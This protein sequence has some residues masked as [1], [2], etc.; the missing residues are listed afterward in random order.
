MTIE[1]AVN[2]SAAGVAI[3]VGIEAYGYYPAPVYAPPP[4]VYAPAAVS[5]AGHQSR[6]P[7]PYQ[8]GDNRATA[9]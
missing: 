6:I 8:V 4:V 7:H 5:V 9:V 2:R 3:T 1:A